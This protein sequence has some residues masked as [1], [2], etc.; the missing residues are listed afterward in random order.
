MAKSRP[1]LS[2]RIKEAL[3]KGGW[4]EYISTASVANY[5][6]RSASVLIYP[7]P[8]YKGRFTVLIEY[9][10]ARPNVQDSMDED[11][12]VKYLT[13]QDAN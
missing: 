3:D 8:S 11:T 10:D 7:V 4:Q 2:G 1:K 9:T 13:H 5:R 6:H 12:L